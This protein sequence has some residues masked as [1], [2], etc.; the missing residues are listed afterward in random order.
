[1]SMIAY[2]AR[3]PIDPT[4]RAD[5]GRGCTLPS[6]GA[7]TELGL[8]RPTEVGVRESKVVTP[9]CHIVEKDLTSIIVQENPPPHWRAVC[10]GRAVTGEV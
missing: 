2:M 3:K 7:Q 8:D 1:M 9:V 4:H 5:D 10:W 6:Q